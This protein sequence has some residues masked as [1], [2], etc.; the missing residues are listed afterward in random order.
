[1]AIKGNF[2]TGVAALKLVL[3]IFSKVQ[4]KRWLLIP[5]QPLNKRCKLC[6]LVTI[7]YYLEDTE[8]FSCTSLLASIL[9]ENIVSPLSP[10][11]G[12][13]SHFFEVGGGTIFPLADTTDEELKRWHLRPSYSQTQRCEQGTDGLVV[14]PK[15]G[16]AVMWY[17]HHIDRGYLGPMNKRALHGNSV[18]ER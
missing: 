2:Q 8:V 9:N 13:P 14:S 6:R 15:K 12:A 16:K 5:L 4:I 1:M 11:I 10:T 17:N 18:A 3:Q 7:L